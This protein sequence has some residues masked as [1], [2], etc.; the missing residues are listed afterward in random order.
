MYL[1]KAKGI[2]MVYIKRTEIY[3]N[4]EAIRNVYQFPRL[5][6]LERNNFDHSFLLD[7]KVECVS[8]HL[9]ALKEDM[10][11]RFKNT[12]MSLKYSSGP[13]AHFNLT[14]NVMRQNYRKNSLTCKMILK[15]KSV[16]VKMAMKN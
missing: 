10:F 16:F 7:A 12:L 6:A 4:N 3:K 2:K 14:K 1:S 5:E 15:T 13:W 8:S 11:E 9:Q